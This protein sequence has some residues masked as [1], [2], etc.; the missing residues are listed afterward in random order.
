MAKQGLN[1]THDLKTNL[2]SF[3]RGEKE[4]VER[5]R[6]SKEEKKRKRKKKRRRKRWDQ[7]QKGMETHLVYESYE[8][9]YEFPCFDA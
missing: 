1:K 2:V 8:I 3:V 4:P 9:K 6:E 7:V 5:E